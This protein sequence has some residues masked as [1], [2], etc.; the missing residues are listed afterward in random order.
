MKTL[1][2]YSLEAWV[3]DMLNQDVPVE[4]IV[5]A[6]ECVQRNLVA[7]YIRNRPVFCGLFTSKEEQADELQSPT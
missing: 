6:F 3:T 5:G 2:I 7:E 1:A 4:A